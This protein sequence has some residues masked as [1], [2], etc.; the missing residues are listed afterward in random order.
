MLVHPGFGNWSN[1]EDPEQSTTVDD[2]LDNFSLYWLANTAASLSRGSVQFSGVHNLSNRVL[3]TANCCSGEEECAGKSVLKGPT[4]SLADNVANL[5]S[6]RTSR[7]WPTVALAC[8]LMTAKRFWHRFNGTSSSSRAPS[9]LCFDVI[10]RD[11]A[12]PGRSRITRPERYR[13]STALSPCQ[14]LG[15][16][17]AD[18]ASPASTS[19]SPLFPSS[20]Q[21]GQRPN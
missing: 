18:N 2:V 16:T 5:K 3:L 4:R 6:R 1:G 19:Q 14:A 9:I 15:C 10:V 20:A 7:I 17:H 13:R 12:E 8:R 21:I 11:A